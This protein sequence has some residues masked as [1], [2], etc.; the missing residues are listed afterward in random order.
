MDYDWQKR[1]IFGSKMS[2]AKENKVEKVRE[3]E[4]TEKRRKNN[5]K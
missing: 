3:L 1:P 4:M 2:F 5:T